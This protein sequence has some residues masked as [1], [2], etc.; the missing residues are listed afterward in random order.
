[1]QKL[2]ARWVPKTLT[3]N[4]KLLRFNHAKKFSETFGANWGRYRNRVITVDETWVS[5]HPDVGIHAT[6]EW[7]YAGESKP[8]RP[9]AKLT[10]LKVM[11]TI[12]WDCRGILLIDYLPRKTT[13]S[14]E[15]YCTILDKLKEELRAHR[16]DYRRHGYWLLQDNARVHTSRRS[17]KK[18]REI[19]LKPMEHPP[20][21]PD[22]SPSD[23]YLFRNLKSELKL[24]TFDR[25]DEIDLFIRAYFELKESD[26]FAAGIDEL[27]ER[28][29]KVI[30]LEGSYIHD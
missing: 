2:F 12:F 30:H 24:R 18:I 6:A 7:R 1:M 20:Y 21:S 27:P 8:E 13:F 15:Y 10:T 11:V 28:M 16:P 14:S 29:Q 3:T 23:Y 19:G 9:S 26:W 4:E 17:M 25:E 22:L 5:Y